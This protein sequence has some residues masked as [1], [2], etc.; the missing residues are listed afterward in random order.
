MKLSKRTLLLPLVLSFIGTLIVGTVPASAADPVTFKVPKGQKTGGWSDPAYHG[1]KEA[2]EKGTEGRVLIQY[3]DPNQLVT[4]GQMLEALRA[5]ISD[6][7]YVIPGYYP[8]EFPLSQGFN[9]PYKWPD[10]VTGN[11]L[12]NALYDKYMNIDFFQMGIDMCGAY[13]AAGYD[14][15]TIEKPISK[16]ED[17]AG[18]RL[19]SNNETTGEIIKALGGIPNFIPGGDVPDALSKGL[20]DG[21]PISKHWALDI[22]LWD[23]GKPGYWTVTGSFPQGLGGM[24][25]SLNPRHKFINLSEDDQQVVRDAC[26]QWGVDMSEGIDAVG[27]AALKEVLSHGVVYHEWPQSEKDRLIEATAHIEQ[28]WLDWTKEKGLPGKLMLTEMNALLKEWRGE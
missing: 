12:W 27:V 1:M 21:N 6:I 18:L 9:L 23:Y 4:S 22:S 10:G 2:I 25:I 15:F 7:G 14:L 24:A 16:M 26:F 11:R 17:A 28:K 20:L 19:R 5:G 13:P 3:F 8:T